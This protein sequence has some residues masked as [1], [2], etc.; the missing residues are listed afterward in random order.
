M[1]DGNICSTYSFAF[2]FAAM[3]KNVT[4]GHPFLW[5][6][7]HGGLALHSHD[8]SWLA[9]CIQNYESTQISVLL[10]LSV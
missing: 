5:S 3:G 6:I 7:I 10:W 2:F 4:L 9:A 1:D 8:S